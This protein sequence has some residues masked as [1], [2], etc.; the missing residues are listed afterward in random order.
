MLFK[1]ISNSLVEAVAVAA[2]KPAVAQ[3]AL[4]QQCRPLRCSVVVEVAALQ[5]AILRMPSLVWQWVRPASYS[6]VSPRP[7][8]FLP[9]PARNLPFSKLARWP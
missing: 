3:W 2:S 5:V 4:Q 1:P 9:A 7:A 8:T 6:T